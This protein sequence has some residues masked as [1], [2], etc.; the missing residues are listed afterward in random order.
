MPPDVLLEF[1]RT[2]H[3]DTIVSAPE[4][5]VGDDDGW[6]RKNVLSRYNDRVELFSYPYMRVFVCLGK[7]CERLLPTDVFFPE[8]LSETTQ[9]FR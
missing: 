4:G 1:R 2:K 5:G 6:L 9:S 8:F 7:L 3:T